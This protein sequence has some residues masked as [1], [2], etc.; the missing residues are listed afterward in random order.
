MQ[1][2]IVLHHEDSIDTYTPE[3]W[4]G[5]LLVIAV[6]LRAFVF[7]IFLATKLPLVEGLVFVVHVCGLFAIIVPLLALSPHKSAK[8]VFTEFNNGGGWPDMGLAFM[9]GLLPVS[10]SLGGIDCVVH[11]GTLLTCLN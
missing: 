9:V 3:A 4:H 5:T 8:Q 2:L 10:G 11:M 1:T 6:I 7:N